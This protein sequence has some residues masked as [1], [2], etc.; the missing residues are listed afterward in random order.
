MELRS[1]VEEVANGAPSPLSVIQFARLAEGLQNQYRDV[2]PKNKTRDIDKSVRTS[3]EHALGFD[4]ILRGERIAI[5]RLRALEEISSQAYQEYI[6]ELDVVQGHYCRLAAAQ[7]LGF[8]NIIQ[9]YVHARGRGKGRP[10]GTRRFL[11]A[12]GEILTE[13]GRRL[14]PERGNPE[15]WTKELRAVLREYLER[16]LIPYRG[17]ENEKDAVDIHARRIAGLPRKKV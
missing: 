17:D 2:I 12:D 13:I 16:G 3:I 6:A 1:R 15:D 9:G 10:E 7:L 14:T 4:C 11:R 5:E 8:M